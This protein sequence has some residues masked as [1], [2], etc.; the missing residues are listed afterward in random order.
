MPGL[1]VRNVKPPAGI[2]RD[3]RRS[4]TARQG[5]TAKQPKRAP[6]SLIRI[7]KVCASFLKPDV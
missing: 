1:L 6:T 4:P 3:P 2:S 7:I 5:F